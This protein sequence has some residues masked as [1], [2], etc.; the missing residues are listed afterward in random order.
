MAITLTGADGP[1]QHA[2]CPSLENNRVFYLPY[3]D[4]ID[5]DVLASRQQEGYGFSWTGTSPGVLLAALLFL[6]DDFANCIFLFFYMRNQFGGILSWLDKHH[7]YDSGRLNR[8]AMYC[9]LFVI[10]GAM[11]S[12]TQFVNNVKQGAW[13]VRQ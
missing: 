1:L 2:V 13:A 11:S 10:M 5:I 4:C 6:I 9:W 7:T 3:F 12:M 8:L